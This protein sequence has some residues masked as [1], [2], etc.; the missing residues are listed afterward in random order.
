MCDIM[1]N[2]APQSAPI[3]KSILAEVNALLSGEPGYRAAT[4][5][6]FADLIWGGLTQGGPQVRKRKLPSKQG[7]LTSAVAIINN[8]KVFQLIVRY[9]LAMC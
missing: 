1:L 6:E 8:A 9:L 4:D 2:R 7:L 5:A 3:A